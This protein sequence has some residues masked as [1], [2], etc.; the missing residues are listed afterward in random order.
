MQRLM[1]LL[2]AILI[3]VGGYLI[4]D[5]FSESDPSSTASTPAAS[6]PIADR[7]TAEGVTPS[8]SDQNEAS[9]PSVSGQVVTI[10]EAST[11][12]NEI[13]P[14]ERAEA[15]AHIT[16][17]APQQSDQPIDVRE[18][19]HFVRGDQML[20]LPPRRVDTASSEVLQEDSTPAASFAVELTSSVQVQNAQTST[21]QPTLSN[22][23]N[24]LIV[25]QPIPPG[26]ESRSGTLVV[27]DTSESTA[28]TSNNGQLTS[29]VNEML[30]LAPDS[31]RINPG[32]SGSL[33]IPATNLSAGGQIRL[34]ELFPDPDQAATSYYY[35]HSVTDADRFGIWGILRQG[36]I[37]T[38][39]EGIQIS[40]VSQFLS[41]QIPED[42][43]RLQEDMSSSY[44][45]LFLH[46][47]VLESV[48]YNFHQGLIGQNPHLIKPGQELVIINFKEEE[49]VGVYNHFARS[50]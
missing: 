39:A 36:L 21:Q 44:L 34:Q 20:T 50:Q 26:S 15:I 47:K 12:P 7:S 49:L 1:I 37:E 5:P 48:V 40:E 29:V 6:S 43:D 41:A 38:F 31:G 19:N 46:Q 23:P 22:Q 10:P 33:S 11:E 32:G 30:N 16:T 8:L 14:E 13:S 25:E 18:A 4:L 3:L 42:A 2:I 24:Q 9:A 27:P 45:G 28:S 35:I 17:L